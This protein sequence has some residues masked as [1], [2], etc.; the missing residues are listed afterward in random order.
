[1]FTDITEWRDTTNKNNELTYDEKYNK[2][3]KMKN[4][5]LKRLHR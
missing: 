5:K 1:M 2:I 4:M 3:R